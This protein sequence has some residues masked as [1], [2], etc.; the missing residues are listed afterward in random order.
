MRCEC[1][2]TNSVDR[3][4]RTG[5]NILFIPRPASDRT[6]ELPFSDP[7]KTTGLPKT[8]KGVT[9]NGRTEREKEKTA[10]MN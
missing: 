4:A 8:S 1:S 10:C 7:L 9:E 5:G 6:V 3:E 2:H